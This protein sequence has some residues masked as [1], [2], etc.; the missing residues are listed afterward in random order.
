MGGSSPTKRTDFSY[1]MDGV[2]PLLCVKDP[3]TPTLPT[4][5]TPCSVNMSRKLALTAGVV[6]SNYDYRYSC[7]SYQVVGIL[8]PIGGLLPNGRIELCIT[9]QGRFS[10]NVAVTGW[11]DP[12][13][14]CEK[15]Q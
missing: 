7:I 11:H 2:G 6:V 5:W 4:K 12:L 10:S 3:E 13:T 14:G 9:P 8:S 1:Q 15:I